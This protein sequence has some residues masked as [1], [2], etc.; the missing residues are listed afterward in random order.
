MIIYKPLKSQWGIIKKF[1][2]LI[3]IQIAN[4]FKNIKWNTQNNYKKQ[5]QSIIACVYTYK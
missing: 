4:I 1:Y 3:R 2:I 5:T